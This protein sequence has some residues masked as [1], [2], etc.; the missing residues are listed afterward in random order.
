MLPK[1]ILDLQV[2]HGKHEFHQDQQLQKI[3]S[4]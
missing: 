1:S 3:L 4:L 2:Q